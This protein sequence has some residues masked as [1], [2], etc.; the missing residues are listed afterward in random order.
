MSLT[1]SSLKPPEE[2]LPS[3]SLTLELPE[4]DDAGLS[5]VSVLAVELLS[6]EVDALPLCALWP[7]EVGELLLPSAAEG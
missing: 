7:E 2:Q 4:P 1:S 5:L 3:V 6:E